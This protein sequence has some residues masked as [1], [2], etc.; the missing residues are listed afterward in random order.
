MGRRER[1]FTFSEWQ[2]KMHGSRLNARDLLFASQRIG[3]YPLSSMV[4]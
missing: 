3:T 1:P 4:A 2:M